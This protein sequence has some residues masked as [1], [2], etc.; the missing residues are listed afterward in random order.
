[1]TLAH[2]TLLAAK[3]LKLFFGVVPASPA[4]KIFAWLQVKVTPNP[5][6][7]LVNKLNHLDGLQNNPSMRAVSSAHGNLKNATKGSPNGDTAPS[8]LL[9]CKRVLQ[10]ALP[11]PLVVL[12]DDLFFFPRKTF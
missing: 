1:M 2:R 12:T 8:T 3:M 11:H 6:R 10:S 7:H 5:S 4:C 9:L